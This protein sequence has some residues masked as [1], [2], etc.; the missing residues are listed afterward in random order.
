M[1]DRIEELG[2]AQAVSNPQSAIGNPQS[3]GLDRMR[4]GH[5]FLGTTNLDLSS[6]TER[7]QTRFQSVRLQPPDSES[8]AAFL[9]RRWGAP[10][11]ITRQIAERA[12]GNVRAAMADFEM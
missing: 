8:L 6:L 2:V 3:H 11:S 7:F 12:K 5:A 9:A 4:P 1:L 10:I